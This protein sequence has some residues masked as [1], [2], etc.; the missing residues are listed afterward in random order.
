[1]CVEGYWGSLVA[2]WKLLYTWPTTN[3]VRCVCQCKVLENHSTVAD[4]FLSLLIVFVI[5]SIISSEPFYCGF[6]GNII[7][8][9]LCNGVEVAYFTHFQGSE[10]ISINITAMLYYVISRAGGASS[11]K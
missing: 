6:S 1:M 9:S 10:R 2:T 7:K 3:P 4:K 11:P 5:S 8:K